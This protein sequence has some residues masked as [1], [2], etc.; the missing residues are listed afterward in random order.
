MSCE[1]VNPRPFNTEARLW[2][3]RAGRYLTAVC[4]NKTNLLKSVKLD[5]NRTP[6]GV[7][8]LMHNSHSVS[9]HGTS[10]N[11][12][13]CI[14][15]TEPDTSGIKPTHLALSKPEEEAPKSISPLAACLPRV[16]WGF[17]SLFFWINS[18]LFSR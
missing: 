18:C 11:H 10:E 1:T 4:K 7:H 2:I 16:V 15:C 6:R 12:S 5:N 17:R 13:W 3:L 14:I 8:I 9:L